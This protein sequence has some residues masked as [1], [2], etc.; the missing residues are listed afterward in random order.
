MSLTYQ[1]ARVGIFK[2]SDL[3]LLS[4]VLDATLPK[5]ASVKEREAHAATLVTLFNAG[6]V[7]EADLVATFMGTSQQ[8]HDK[9]A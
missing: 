6:I 3:E 5:G 7:N 4:R 8:L 1:T 9:V 2:P